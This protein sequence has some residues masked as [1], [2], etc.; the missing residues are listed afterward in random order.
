MDLGESALKF[1]ERK[2]EGSLRVS[3]YPTGSAEV[4][5]FS[6]FGPDNLQCT[7]KYSKRGQPVNEL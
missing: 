6:V 2:C 1:F 5:S 4:P 3:V 7:M